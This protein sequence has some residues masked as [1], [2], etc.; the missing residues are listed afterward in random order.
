[1]FLTVAGARVVGSSAGGRDVGSSY[2]I[3][4]VAISR[5]PK[6]HRAA[7]VGQYVPSR[8]LPGIECLVPND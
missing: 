4:W 8:G 2:P 1:M 6:S 5:E 3:T 7:T